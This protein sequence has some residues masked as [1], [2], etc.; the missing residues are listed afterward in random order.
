[1]VGIGTALADDPLLTARGGTQPR[2]PPTRIVLD[3]HLRLPLNAALLST[4]M[5]APVL[6]VAGPEAPEDRASALHDAGAVVV[7]VP[8]A[9]DGGLDVDAVMA[10][11]WEQDIRS[12]LCEGGGRV[13]SSLI[14]ASAV[15][16]LN[17]FYTPMLLGPDAVPAFD[18]QGPLPLDPARWTAPRVCTHG[19]DV[20]VTFDRRSG[21]EPGE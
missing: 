20:E 12:V 3:S 5:D 4:V 9:E 6:V 15:H 19:H 10:A 17:L 2:I 14:A 8:A 7:R 16:R 13:A 18:L 11:L 21:T 1:M